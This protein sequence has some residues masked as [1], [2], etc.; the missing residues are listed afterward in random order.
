MNAL[1][2]PSACLLGARCPAHPAPPQPACLLSQLPVSPL[3]ALSSPS[4]NAAVCSSIQADSQPI[5][6]GSA[7]PAS[8]PPSQPPS[9]PRTRP[10]GMTTLSRRPRALQGHALQRSASAV[11]VGTP[12]A[13][14]GAKAHPRPAPPRRRRGP[15]PR[16]APPRP[17]PTHPPTPPTHP[18][19]HHALHPP[20]CL[21][22]SQAPPTMRRAGPS[23]P[24]CQ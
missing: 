5:S 21:Q 24:H 3:R 6:V 23:A 19:P 2:V 15:P 17:P 20:T 14:S 12:V 4:A 8:Q 22:L 13:R 7:R 11:G 10:Q 16:P 9:Q 18:P 1:Q